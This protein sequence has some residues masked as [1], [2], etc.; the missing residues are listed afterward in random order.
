MLIPEEPVDDAIERTGE[1][2][3]SQPRCLNH[4]CANRA[5]L[6]VV[7]AKIRLCWP[8]A[9]LFEGVGHGWVFRPRDL[10]N[11]VSTLE[12]VLGCICCC[13]ETSPDAE[14]SSCM[15]LYLEARRSE[16]RPALAKSVVSVACQSIQ[17]VDTA[18]Q[19]TRVCSEKI[20]GTVF[21]CI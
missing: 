3:T 4:T 18:P 13:L 10:W 2:C 8:V 16:P 20:T 14:R 6:L 21:L 11:T 1:I 5:S 17:V 9:Q 19:V 15:F 12:D 7:A